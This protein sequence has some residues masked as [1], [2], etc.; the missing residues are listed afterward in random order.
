MFIELLAEHQIQLSRAAVVPI[1]VEQDVPIS[2][3]LGDNP[4]LAGRAQKLPVVVTGQA[5]VPRRPTFQRET[6]VQR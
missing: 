1:A 6:T 3:V 2:E 5:F 4:I